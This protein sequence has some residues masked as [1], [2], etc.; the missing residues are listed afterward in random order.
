MPI[1]QQKDDARRLLRWTALPPLTLAEVLA[2]FDTQAGE[3]LWQ[4]G[5]VVDLRSA[6][7]PAEEA[8]ALLAGI[9]ELAARHGPPGPV[10]LVTTRAPDVANAQVYSIRSAKV[11]FRVEV[12]WDIDE[13]LKWLDRHGH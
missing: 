9:T 13:A 12:F 4:Y 7:L 1:Q 2:Q 3:G 8:R 5:L 10:A 6:I 11:G